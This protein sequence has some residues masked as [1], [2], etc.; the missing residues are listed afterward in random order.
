MRWLSLLKS[1]IDLRSAIPADRLQAVRQLLQAADPTGIGLL[2]VALRDQ[3]A[4]VRAKAAEALGQLATL[5]VMRPLIQA[6]ADT[7]PPVR[8]SATQAL[9]AFSGPNASLLLLPSVQHADP[10]T[11]MLIIDS[12]AEIGDE[13][14]VEA[15]LDLLHNQNE[16][17]REAAVRALGKIGGA[18]AIDP[19]LALLRSDPDN[20]VRASAAEALGKIGDA[21]A[22]NGLL[23]SLADNEEWVQYRAVAALIGFGA[24]A[25]DPLLFLL[26]RGLPSVR[27]R[28]AWALGRVGD[29]RAYEPLA[30][31]LHEKNP[32]LRKSAA[33]A[34]GHLGDARAMEPLNALLNDENELVRWKA[35]QALGELGDFRIMHPLIEFITHEHFA[36]E[37][38]QTLR[39]MLVTRPSGFP[40][41]DLQTLVKLDI[42]LSRLTSATITPALRNDISLVKQ[43][44][45]QEVMRR[46]V[47]TEVV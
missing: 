6:S 25:L 27:A 8:H 43:L 42:V 23:A 5:V 29:P 19:L 17:I 11:C 15:L 18:R 40:L 37:A 2:L 35:L 26:T 21:H 20:E 45:R 3:D 28:A 10:D 47:A 9:R 32:D 38:L 30:H 41:S 24:S 31:A 46:E 14:D 1:S 34:L 16:K 4:G 12:L 39:D 44:A 13:R 22:L 33:E 7:A 36:E